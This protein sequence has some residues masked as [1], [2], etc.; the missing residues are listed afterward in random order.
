MVGSPLATLG[1]VETVI[2]RL[3]ARAENAEAALMA[4]NHH[5]V[6]IH[7]GNC[8]GN[9]PALVCLGCCQAQQ[10]RWFDEANKAEATLRAASFCEAHWPNP[11]E[12][13]KCCPM[14]EAVHQA[15]LVKQAEA[16]VERLR[17]ED[18]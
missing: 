12:P 13:E 16:E 14:C 4:A 1:D 10:E 5:P 7:D 6:E 11:E 3:T 17:A 18:D 2:K 9:A 8:K 15:D